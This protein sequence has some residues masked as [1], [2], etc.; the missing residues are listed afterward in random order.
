MTTVPEELRIIKP[1]LLRAFEIEKTQPKYAMYVRYYCLKIA[2]GSVKQGKVNLT[3]EGN[4]YLNNS[5][6]ELEELKKKF[7]FNL[8]NDSEGF[9]IFV[10]SLFK[11]CY[12]KDLGGQRDFKISA[13]YFS[14]VKL[15]DVLLDLF[16]ITYDIAKIREIQL[17]AKKRCGLIHRSLKANEVCPDPPLFELA[18]FDKKLEAQ[19]DDEEEQ[20][21]NE[22]ISQDSTVPTKPYVYEPEVEDTT[23]KSN[24]IKQ[25]PTI[26]NNYSKTP[27]TPQTT[28]KDNSSYVLGKTS[29]VSPSDVQS[30]QKLCKYTTAAIGRHD[31]I[32]SRENIA[33]MLAI[34][35]KYE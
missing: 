31:L 16:E 34:L 19:L 27:Q 23:Q 25:Q 24:F 14:F 30:I 22:V 13:S 1:Y 17:F 4:I 8:K 35:E 33:E 10:L 12:Q 3:E 29:N 32:E 18:A 5:M 6:T 15:V 2:F 26:N 21:E 7:S 20:L 9:S 11:N 28:T